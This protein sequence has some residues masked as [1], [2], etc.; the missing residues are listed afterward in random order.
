[1]NC[2]NLAKKKFGLS[3]FYEIS[4][5]KKQTKT[6]MVGEELYIGPY[7]FRKTNSSML[8]VYFIYLINIFREFK[9]RKC[10]NTQISNINM[11]FVLYIKVIFSPPISVISNQCLSK[12]A[13]LCYFSLSQG[14]TYLVTDDKWQPWSQEFRQNRRYTVVNYAVLR[15]P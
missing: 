11:H 3:P 14:I 13:T 10:F 7:H 2:L 9:L 4:S 8:Y 6:K 15:L 1:M 5:S 12:K